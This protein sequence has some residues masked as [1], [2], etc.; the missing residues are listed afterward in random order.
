[1][2]Y[3]FGLVQVPQLETSWC[4]CIALFCFSIGR[5]SVNGLYHSPM[6]CPSCGAEY[7]DGFTR[8]SDC[9]LPLVEDLPHG[10]T[11]AEATVSEFPP[12]EFL[13]WFAPISIVATFTPILLLWRLN[14]SRFHPLHIVV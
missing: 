11:G 12:R 8:C 14:P 3:Y 6:F 13:S 7:R 1:M 9:A 5:F 10:W 4:G 2:H